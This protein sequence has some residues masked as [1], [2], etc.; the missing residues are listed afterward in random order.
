MDRNIEE[1]AE[2]TP[3]GPGNSIAGI[4][5]L[6]NTVS[7]LGDVV[8]KIADQ[9]E[10]AA[11]L[12]ETTRAQNQLNQRIGQLVQ[13]ASVDPDMSADRHKYY[14][15]QL[16][17]AVSDAQQYIT[18]PS[19]KEQFNTEAQDNANMANLKINAIR[20]KK[21]I[22]LNKAELETFQQ[23]Q[24][25]NYLNAI[26]PVEKQKALLESDR[27]FDESVQGGYMTPLQA[28]NQKI[29]RNQ[30]WDENQA[31]L[32]RHA[33]PDRTLAELQ[34]GANGAYKH[35]TPPQRDKLI[36]STLIFKN[37]MQKENQELTAIARNASE[38]ALIE[39]HLDGQLT[40]K[41][42]EDL[43]SQK[44]ISDS[45]ADS[46]IKTLSEPVIVPNSVQ[47]FKAY[48]D[49]VKKIANPQTSMDDINGII[50]NGLKNHQLTLDEAKSI[51]RSTITD[52]QGQPISMTKLIQENRTKKPDDVIRQRTQMENQIKQN[53][54]WWA[55][56]LNAIDTWGRKNQKTAQELADLSRRV[57]ENMSMNNK[58]ADTAL[59]TAR[60]L[61]NEE[62]IKSNPYF[63]ALPEKGG[64]MQDKV[65]GAL[66][67]CTRDGNCEE[68][69]P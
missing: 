31:L 2:L 43:H 56:A 18:L 59:G 67:W 39:K 44:Q 48:Q 53:Q 38:A 32:D 35:L 64:W 34:K 54:H 27:K 24:E 41:E 42:V 4:P 3:E 37:K 57:F 69:Q 62:N 40:T 15:D 45:F 6:G 30:S 10:K 20:I 28:A 11:L 60:N 14:S 26:N 46:M 8:T 36:T 7:S 17:Q 9:Y 22:N 65:T 68:K 52:N 47:R 25:T 12:G 50:T 1:T 55:S 23:N 16:Q 51:W 5:A 29:K 33:D 19:A 58:K 49:I 66:V 61:I 21:Y 13:E 63:S